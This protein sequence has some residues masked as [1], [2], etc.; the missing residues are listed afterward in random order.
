[1]VYWS[2]QDVVAALIGG[3]LIAITTSLNLLLYGRITGLSG[4]FNSVI[5]YDV[6][7]GFE[8]KLAFMTGLI[9]FP[10]LMY[11]IFGAAIVS[12][13]FYFIMFDSNEY[14]DYK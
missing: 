10:V 6:K 5:K 8:W 7:A 12:G 11:E 14:I 9:T 1:M 13:N 3:T 4:I 2:T